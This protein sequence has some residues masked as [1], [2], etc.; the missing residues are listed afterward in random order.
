MVTTYFSPVLLRACLV[1][2]G[3]WLV[4]AV[5]SRPTDFYH[6]CCWLGGERPMPNYQEK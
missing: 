1:R 2:R 6:R 5:H 3:V 4:D